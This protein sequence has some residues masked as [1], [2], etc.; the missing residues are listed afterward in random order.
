VE[1]ATYYEGSHRYYMLS[2]RTNKQ[3]A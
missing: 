2:E 3:V 1:T